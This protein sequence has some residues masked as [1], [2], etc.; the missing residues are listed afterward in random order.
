MDIELDKLGKAIIIAA[1]FAAVTVL[2]AG[3]LTDQPLVEM[4]HIS[5]IL[6]VAA[7]PEAMPAVSTITLSRGMRIMA[8]HKALVKTLSAVETFGRYEYHCQ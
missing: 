1:L 6:A 8:E 5:I 3:L 4:L 2:I 7:I